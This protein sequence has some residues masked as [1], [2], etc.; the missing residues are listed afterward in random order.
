MK[1]GA[2]GLQRQ[3]SESKDGAREEQEWGS[4]RVSRLY[5]TRKAPRC[6]VRAP[7]RLS[8]K[9]APATETC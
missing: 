4:Q 3:A 7:F 2:V 1:N 6:P 5:V 9:P 8:G